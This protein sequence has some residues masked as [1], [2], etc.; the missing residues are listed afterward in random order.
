MMFKKFIIPTDHMFFHPAGERGHVYKFS[1][2]LEKIGT[3]W[4]VAIANGTYVEVISAP[5][6]ITRPQYGQITVIKVKADIA[7]DYHTII[8]E[9]YVPAFCI[10]KSEDYAVKS[11]ELAN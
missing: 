1:T 11:P 5:V 8:K 4:D 10:I 6:E 3:E 7:T 9:F 2:D